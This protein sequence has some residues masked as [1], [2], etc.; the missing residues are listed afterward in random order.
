MSFPPSHLL[1][2]PFSLFHDYLRICHL[3]PFWGFRLFCSPIFYTHIAPL[4]L[5]ASRF[6]VL[7]LSPFLASP[8]SASL[9]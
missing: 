4:G 7:S 5:N 1:V 2:F 6:P 3:P 8:S 9:R